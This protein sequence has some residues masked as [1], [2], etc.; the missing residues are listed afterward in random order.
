MSW[1]T[2]DDLLYGLYFLLASS[3]L[4]GPFNMVSPHC[5]SNKEFTKTLAKVLHRPALL[6]LPA[7][8]VKALFGEM[9]KALLL[10]SSGVIPNRLQEAGFQFCYPDLR[11]GLKH[12]LGR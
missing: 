8:G 12:I 9:G 6:P 1:I 5:L 3:D 4:E 2:L 7:V 11:D 10:Q